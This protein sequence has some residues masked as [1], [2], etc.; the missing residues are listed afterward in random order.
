MRKTV[1][2]TNRRFYARA[3]AV[4]VAGLFAIALVAPASSAGD[5]PQVLALALSPNHVK[6][7]K[8]VVG[9]G[10][11]CGTVTITNVSSFSGL[12]LQSIS[13]SENENVF[14]RST[15]CLLGPSMLPGASCTV[16]VEFDPIEPGSRKAKLLVSELLTGTYSVGVNGRGV[17]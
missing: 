14:T 16:Q 12:F 8:A 4:T 15:T 7:G 13:F 6:C 5:P 10:T 3:L 9:V 17:L 11:T 1:G 2:T